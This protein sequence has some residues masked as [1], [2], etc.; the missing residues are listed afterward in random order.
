MFTINYLY[1]SSEWLF[2]NFLNYINYNLSYFHDNHLMLILF[3]SFFFAFFLK[4][5]LTP[6]HLFKVELYKGMPFISIFFYTT[7]YFLS[8][9]LFFVLII[10]NYM[11]SYKNYFYVPIL[12]FII[13]GSLYLINLIFD[14]SSIKSFFAYSSIINS[15]FFIFSTIILF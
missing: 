5:G 12:L 9:F 3:S 2:L 11:H 1:N 8:F 6:L 13:F 10:S 4:I 15:T 7:F 14:I